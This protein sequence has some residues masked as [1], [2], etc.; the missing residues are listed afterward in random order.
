MSGERDGKQAASEHLSLVDSK[1]IDW[2]AQHDIV[3][4]L[5]H[6]IKEIKQYS[7]RDHHDGEWLNSKPQE[8]RD[9]YCWRYNTTY[10]KYC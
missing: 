1:E 5:Y 2:D 10:R 4:E 3:E 9:R 7:H 8:F 6:L